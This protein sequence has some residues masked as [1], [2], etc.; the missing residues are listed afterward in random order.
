[1]LNTEQ[2]TLSKYRMEKAEECLLSA[3]HLFEIDDYSAAAN[4][5]YYAVFH[6]IRA[7]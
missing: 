7:I 4:R 1:M 2:I 3:K 6:T 5:S